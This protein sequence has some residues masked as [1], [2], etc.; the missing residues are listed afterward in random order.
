MADLWGTLVPLIVGSV[1]PPIQLVVTILLLRSERGRITAVAWVAGMIVAR[2]VIGAL[3]SL[4]VSSDEVDAVSEVGGAQPVL[5][6]VLL[7]VALLFLTM[8]G[9]KLLAGDDPDAPPPAWITKTSTMT[10]G[11]AFLLG[12]ALMTV[13][14]K[15]LVFTVGAATATVEAQVSQ[16]AAVASFVAFAVLASGQHL[17]VLLAAIAAPERSAPA[18]DRVATTL[19]ERSRVVMIGLSLVFGVWFFVKALDAFAIL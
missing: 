7:I 8:A 9:R 17:L 5:G 15:F 14:V 4:F 19:E 2:L 12:A 6:T 1:L 16:T 13:G 3:V 11:T 10:P 18:L